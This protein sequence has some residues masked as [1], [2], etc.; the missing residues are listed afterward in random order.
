MF[1]SWCLRR[2]MCSERL[3]SGASKANSRS[4]G[5]SRRGFETFGDTPHCIS[6]LLPPPPPGLTWCCTQVTLPQRLPPSRGGLPSWRRGSRPRLTWDLQG[7]PCL[8]LCPLPSVRNG[9]F[10]AVT[11]W[12]MPS[13]ELQRDRAQGSTRR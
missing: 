3:S 12:E 4:R 8:L 5:H 1:I 9:E 2:T 11:A 13:R 10:Q 6:C 7:A